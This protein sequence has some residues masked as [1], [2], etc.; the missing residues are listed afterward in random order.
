[1]SHKHTSTVF[2]YVVVWF[3]LM[4]LLLATVVAADIHLDDAFF[5]GAN[6]TL[7]M[8]IALVKMLV[9]ML[10]FM[11][12]K[13]ASKLTWISAGASFV[14]LAILIGL[15]LPDYHTRGQ[16]PGWETPVNDS[17]TPG[18]VALTDLAEQRSVG[19]FNGSAPQ[20][21]P[22]SGTQGK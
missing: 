8:L 5:P 18:H 21:G 12:V 17:Y 10:W 22:E 2:T 13:D 20:S 7:A 1:M 19:A 9:V 11:H 16:F 6:I 3:V 15:T 4:V 14:W